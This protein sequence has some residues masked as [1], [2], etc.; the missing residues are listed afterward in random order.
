MPNQPTPTQPCNWFDAVFDV[1]Q[2]APNAAAVQEDGRVLGYEDLVTRAGQL[3]AWLYERGLRPG[4]RLGIHLRK[5]TEEIVATL[6]SV[7]LGAV[8]VHIHPQLTTE[9]LRHVIL[10]SGLRVL[11]TEPRRASAVRNDV[12]LAAHLSLIVVVGKTALDESD[13]RLSCWPELETA[14]RLPAAPPRREQL[15]A[16]LYTSGSTGKPKGVMHSQANLVSFAA[17]VA[18]YLRVTPKDRVLGLLPVSFGYGLS[19]VLTTLY[20]GATLVLQKAPFPA[21]VVKSALHERITGL[22]AVPSLWN[23]LL[24]YL[25]ERPTALPDVRYVTNAGGHLSTANGRRLRACLPHA[26]IVLM[27]GST[28]TLRSTYLP[29]GDF[30]SK[31]GAMGRAIPNVEVFVIKDNK[32]CEA[33]EPGE[34]VHRGGHLSQGYWNNTEETARRFRR[35][36]ALQQHGCDEPVY[37]SGDLVRRDADGVLWFVSRASWMV[38]SG[39]FRFSLGEVEE[40]LLASGLVIQAAALAV[41]DAMLGQAVHA[42]VT[43]P[44]GSAF[45]PGALDRY[46]WKAM[47]SYMMPKSFR[48]WEGSLPLL[49]NGKLDRAQLYKQV[50]IEPLQVRKR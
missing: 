10:D 15:A 29:P 27:Y 38:K 2:H 36:P 24:D 20:V 31:M 45:D 9:Q 13:G 33:D 50:A 46:C 44:E 42:V 40:S 21:E 8:F 25:D 17:G 11:V 16:L 49:P 32:I 22:A 48:L 4:D 19:Q 18:Q 6:A 23:Q 35:A 12:Q 39:G 34:L 41:D 30:D 1:A 28:E 37:H 14:L 47:P 26:D 43:P 3:A 5:S 7:R